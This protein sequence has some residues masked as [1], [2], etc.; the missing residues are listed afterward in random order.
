MSDKIERAYDW[1]S[2][3]TIE[4]NQNTYNLMP[5]GTVVD[6]SVEKIEKKRNAK[7]NCPQMEIWLK[8]ANAECGETWVRET[9]SL[10]SKAQ[11]FINAF[12][13]AIGLQGENRTFGSLVEAA[14]GRVGR[15]RLKVESWASKSEKKD[16]GTPVMYS[17]NKIDKY[18]K[19]ESN[20]P[21]AKSDSDDDDC[22]F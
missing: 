2:S 11:Y 6:F 15:A 4:E 20:A 9:I 8:C 3:V 12:F 14:I 19:A 5:A 13:S 21:Q 10:H 1:D 16:D 18:L 22:P 7:L 17:A